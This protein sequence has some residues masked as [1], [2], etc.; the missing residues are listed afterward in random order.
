MLH[1]HGVCSVRDRSDSD[2]GDAGGGRDQLVQTSGLL[3]E[4]SFAGEACMQIHICS[5]FVFAKA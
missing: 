1:T 5:T 4:K 3:L 2:G